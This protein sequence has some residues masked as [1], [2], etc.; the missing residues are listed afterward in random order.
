MENAAARA[1]EFEHVQTVVVIGRNIDR[2][3]AA[4]HTIALFGPSA[5]ALG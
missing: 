5:G 1:L 4:Y 2:D 3:D